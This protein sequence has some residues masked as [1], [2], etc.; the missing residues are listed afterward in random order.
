[1]KFLFIDKKVH[2]KELS[3]ILLESGSDSDTVVRDAKSAV[4]QLNGN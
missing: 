1:M 4:Q 2:W 3:L